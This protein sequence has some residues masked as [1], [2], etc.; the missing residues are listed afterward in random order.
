MKAAAERR[1]TL[2]SIAS[3]EKKME[4]PT[5]LLLCG[6]RHDWDTNILLFKARVRDIA[7]G[8]AVRHSPS[9]CFTCDSNPFQLFSLSTTNPSQ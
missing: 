2:G 8:M 6:W 9:M 7:M 4:K 3:G 1:D 5:N